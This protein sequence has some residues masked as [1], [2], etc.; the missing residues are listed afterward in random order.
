MSHQYYDEP[1]EPEE[2]Q[3]DP[4]PPAGSTP[5]GTFTATVAREEIVSLV[6]DRFL[7]QM[8]GYYGDRESLRDTVQDQLRKLVSE[9]AHEHIE[10]ITAA[11]VERAV[12]DLLE[13][14]WP[15]TDSYG[16]ETGRMTVKELVLKGLTEHNSYDRETKA[17]TLAKRFFEEAIKKDID[18]LIKETQQKLR[19]LLNTKVD[20]ALRTALL[21]ALGLR[22]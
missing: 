10:A 1:E 9:A 2:P 12:G 20:E 7:A 17:F 3:T 18:P 19:A 22:T 5:A 6:A 15:K 8:T 4:E 13:N 21:S 14:G 16:K 11:A